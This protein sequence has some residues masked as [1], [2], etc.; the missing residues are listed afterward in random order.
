M[1][2]PKLLVV[3]IAT[4]LWTQTAFGQVSEA[5]VWLGELDVQVAKLRL[6]VRLEFGEDGSPTAK[7]FSLDQNN[8][9]IAV[10]SFEVDGDMV[11]MKMESVLASFQGKMSEDHTECVGT[12]TQAGR[13]FPLTFKKV[14]K[15]PVRTHIVNWV[16]TLK[17]GA[18]EFEFQLRVFED[19]DGKRSAVLD[20]FSE[21]IEGLA[22]NFT[23]DGSEMEFEVPVSAGKFVGKL[24]E[25]K[26]KIEGKWIQSGGEYDLSFERVDVADTRKLTMNRPQTP[27]EPFPYHVTEISIKNEAAPGV[28]LAGTLTAPQ[29]DGPFAT[30]V[31]VSG[32]GPQDRDETL[33]GHKPFAVLADH[34][35][36]AGIAVFRFDDRGVGQSKGNFATATSEDFASDVGAIVERLREHRNV[37]QDRIGIIGHSEGGLIAPMVAVKD[38]KLAFIVLMA[39][40]GVSGKEILLKQ[41]REISADSGV[42]QEALDQNE[43]ILSMVLDRITPDNEEKDVFSTVLE[44]YKQTLSEEERSQLDIPEDA[45]AQFA[46]F[47]TPWFRFFNVYDPAPTLEKVACAVLSVIGE[48]D[49]QVDCDVN[50][51]AIRAALTKGGNADFQISNL[52]D[53]NHLFQRCETG[54][55]SEYQKIEE[56]LNPEFL[57][58]V[59]R[60][61]LERVD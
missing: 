49:L 10:D 58:L 23:Q 14:D 47:E 44:E 54:N 33:V 40:P 32:S 15:V 59:T 46:Q 9:E 56:T 30:V 20:S 31:L 24:N 2:S 3:I 53:L 4:L 39:G 25:D 43:K 5:E 27:K 19:D 36:R 52:A 1:N 48:K 22:T 55:P 21:N 17:A 18:Q 37:R 45:K 13:E 35:T 16:G 61:I 57:N 34:L 38:S 7:L 42:P 8:A 6:E 11:A 51:A 50:Q 26:S 12:F 28:V 41:S 60:W 29:G